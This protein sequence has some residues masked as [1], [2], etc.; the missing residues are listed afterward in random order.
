VRWGGG[1]PS[2]L[3]LNKEIGMKTD[4]VLFLVVVVLLGLVGYLVLGAV[5]NVI[6]ALTDLYAHSPLHTLGGG[7]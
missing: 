6:V 7:I 2:L 3:T 5:E 1:N 4:T